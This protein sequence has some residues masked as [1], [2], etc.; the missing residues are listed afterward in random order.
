MPYYRCHHN[1]RSPVVWFPTRHLSF[2]QSRC[3]WPNSSHLYHK[4]RCLVTQLTFYFYQVSRETELESWRSQ[5]SSSPGEGQGV[6]EHSAHVSFA[7]A[8]P[9]AGEAPPWTSARSA[10]TLPSSEVT[11]PVK[12]SYVRIATPNITCWHRPRML[13][14]LFHCPYYLLIYIIYELVLLIL[15]SHRI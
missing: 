7:F 1:H 13:Y 8:V 10:P 15:F 3:S 5:M 11:F 4:Q 9:S 2:F 14:F 12:A 6:C